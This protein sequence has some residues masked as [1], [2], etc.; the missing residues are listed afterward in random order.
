MKFKGTIII[1]DPCYIIRAEH[2]GT[3]PISKDDWNECNYGRNM[4]KLGIKTYLTRST[5]YGDWSCTTVKDTPE[6]EEALKKLNEN[7][8]K[9]WNASNDKKPKRKLIKS[10][11]KEREEITANYK[12]FILGNFCADAGLVSVFLLD[13][14]LAYNPDFDYHINR[15]WTTTLIN[16][17][18][19]NI[20]I[21]HRNG[22]VSVIGK[23]NINFF[24]TQTGF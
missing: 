7:Y 8:S 4:E 20:E 23:G 16:D 17:F 12:N 24:T 9:L 22:E 18:D 13:E 21:T 11:E 14:V 19:G 3:K 10:L 5:E 1:T 6:S 2:H 15:L